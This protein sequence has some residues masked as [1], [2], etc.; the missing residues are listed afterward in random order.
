MAAAAVAAIV[1]GA[2]LLV[3]CVALMVDA[4]DR[5]AHGRFNPRPPK[6][7]STA[8]HAATP[9]TAPRHAGGKLAHA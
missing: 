8:R 7:R 5:G 9:S 3:V 2:F 6:L 1:L 4:V